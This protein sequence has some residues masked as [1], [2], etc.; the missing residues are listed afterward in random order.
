MADSIYDEE[1]LAELLRLKEKE[2]DKLMKLVMEA[3]REN[4]ESVIAEQSE[5]SKKKKALTKLRNYFEEQE[6]YENCA[7]LLELEKKVDEKS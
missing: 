5:V 3:I 4:P 1:F 2:P 7:L 6:E